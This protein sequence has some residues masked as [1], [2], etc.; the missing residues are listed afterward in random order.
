MRDLIDDIIEREGGSK[1]TND[2]LDAGGRTKYGISERANPDLWVNGP[3]TYEQA[4]QRFAERYVLPFNGIMDPQMLE[5]LAD[6][7][8][9]SGSDKVI[10]ILQQIVGA[11]IDGVLGPKSL[12]K[13][14]GYPAGLV[15]GVLVPG[16]VRLNIAIRDARAMH[17]AGITKARPT[18]LRFI[19][20]W[21]RRS[22]EFL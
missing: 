2:P 18:N 3:P 21:L 6:W 10:R 9:T 16:S 17:Y 14:A 22:Q 1:E 15:F 8:V 20:G 5:Q 7:A 19:F 4:R 11:G 12:A 13:V